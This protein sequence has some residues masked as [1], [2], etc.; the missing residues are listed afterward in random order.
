MPMKI[1]EGDTAQLNMTPMIDIVFN[2]VTFFMLTL[3]MSHKE[4]AVLDLPRA[5]SGI[6]DKAP[7]TDPDPDKKPED[8]VR[9]TINLEIST[10]IDEKTG[11]EIGPAIFFR[12]Q[13]Y[14]VGSDRTPQEQD[15]ALKNLRS[16]LVALHQN[17]AMN[18]REPD[19][20][21]RVMILIRGDRQSKWQFVQWIMQVCADPALKIYKI[22]FA[23]DHPKEQ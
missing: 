7:D 13:R 23:V 5:H 2:L 15:L 8:K 17:R 9:F 12:G 21:S 20:S 6:E 10:Q 18:L 16:D 19:G 1:P 4:L 14:P 11:R 3:D 22:H